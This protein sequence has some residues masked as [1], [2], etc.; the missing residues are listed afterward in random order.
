MSSLQ[1]SQGLGR[2]GGDW[3]A[4]PVE[5]GDR[6]TGSFLVLGGV[7]RVS[8]KILEKNLG[9]ARIGIQPEEIGNRLIVVAQLSE[10]HAVAVNLLRRH[11]QTRGVIHGSDLAARLL[12][13]FGQPRFDAHLGEH[14][15]YGGLFRTQPALLLREIAQQ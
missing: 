14:A 4:I 11:Q 1:S 2:S 7:E 15:G 5:G 12:K 3:V 9:V 10:K 8:R 13:S 6:P